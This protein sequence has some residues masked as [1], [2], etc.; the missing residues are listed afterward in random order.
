MASAVTADLLSR[1]AFGLTPVFSIT[2]EQMSPLGEYGHAALLGALLGLL[3]ILYNRSVAFAQSLF[4]KLRSGWLRL[5]PPFLAAGALGFCC[6]RCSAAATRW[7]RTPPG[8]MPRCSCA[9]SSP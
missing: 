4:G 7:W 2:V 5:L 9:C 8:A 1:Q 3:G 6:R